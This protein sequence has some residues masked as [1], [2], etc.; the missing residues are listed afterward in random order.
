MKRTFEIEFQD[1][2]GPLWMN[3]DNLLICLLNTCRNTVFTVRDVT[4]DGCC[5]VPRTA[6]PATSLVDEIMGA[7]ARGWCSPENEHKVMDVHLADAITKEVCK[8]RGL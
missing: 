5:D 3:T 2:H 6:G 8:V 1:D 4:G 7:V